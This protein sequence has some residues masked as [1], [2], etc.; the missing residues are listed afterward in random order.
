MKSTLSLL[1][2]FS[3]ILSY[4][5]DIEPSNE[6]IFSSFTK[7]EDAPADNAIIVQDG[8]DQTDNI[9]IREIASEDLFT[10]TPSNLKQHFLDKPLIECDGHL[11][12]MDEDLVLKLNIKINTDKARGSYGQLENGSVVRLRLD[13]GTTVYG[14]NFKRNKGR[15]NSEKG[16]TVYR[17]N[18]FIKESDLKLLSKQRIEQIGIVW[19]NGYELYDN[20]NMD[21]FIRQLQIINE[22]E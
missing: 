11:I 13:D 5:Q 1:L 2:C 18:Y 6:S 16:Y 20:Y 4:A 9:Y 3:W 22:G 14:T 8:I 19:S 12:K 15:I 21:F 7:L 17:G 10:F